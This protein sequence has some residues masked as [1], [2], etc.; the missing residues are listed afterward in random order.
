MLQWESSCLQAE[1]GELCSEE[2]V[3]L[4]GIALKVAAVS[5]DMPPIFLLQVDLQLLASHVRYHARLVTHTFL[6]LYSK[7]LTVV[8][9][10]L[11]KRLC[12]VATCSLT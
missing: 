1:G 5:G 9:T 6:L 3:T 2:T 7:A 8:I 4:E 10:T 11:H 12:S